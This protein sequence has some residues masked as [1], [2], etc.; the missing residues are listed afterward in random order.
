MERRQRI[1][2]LGNSL[3]LNA[4]GESLQRSGHFD[5]ITM[6]LPKDVSALEPMKPDAVLFDLE[7]PHLES[8]FSLSEHCAKLL[9]VGVSPGT[10]IVKVWAGQH[11]RE[12][13]IQGLLTVIKDQL[14]VSLI[15]G[16]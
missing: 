10:N 12:L 16:E 7:T 13:S 8:I 15:G 14:D 9:L 4:L 5:L 11:L 1:F 3:I 6:D 2:I